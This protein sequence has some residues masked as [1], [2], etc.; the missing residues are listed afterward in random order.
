MINLLLVGDHPCS[1][2]GNGHMMY[3]IAKQID[4]SKIKFSILATKP[5]TA[6]ETESLFEV[7]IWN[8]ID[9][10]SERNPNGWMATLTNLTQSKKQRVDV[11]LFVGHDLWMF[12]Q[13]LPSLTQLKNEK[14]FIIASLFPFD[15]ISVK[16]YILEWLKHIDLPLVYSKYGYDMLKPHVKDIEYFRPPLFDADQ[17]KPYSAKEKVAARLEFSKGLMK[18]DAFVF[19]FFGANQWRKDPQRLIKSFFEVKAKEKK[20]NLYLH[21]ELTSGIFNIDK[22]MRDCGDPAGF[23]FIKK[24]KYQYDTKGMVDAYNLVDCMVNTSW[25]E[26]LSWTLVEAM[27]CGT[28]IIAANNTAQMELIKGGAAFP[29]KCNELAYLPVETNQGQS[30]IETIACD[31]NHL[32]HQMLKAIR[33]PKLLKET[34]LKGLERAKDWISGIDDINKAIL[35]AIEKRKS[36]KLEVKEEPSNSKIKAVLFAQHS[37][38]GDVF[39]TTKAFKGVKKMYSNLPIVYMTMPQ[40]MDIIINNPYID[41]VIPWNEKIEGQYQFNL[42]PHRDRIGPGHWGRNSNSILSDFYWK[43][44]LVEPDDFFIEKVEP[45]QNISLSIT[46]E[47]RPI[48]ILHTTGGDAA[49]RTYKYMGDIAEALKDRYFTIQLGGPKDYPANAQL[50]LRGALSYRES[51]WVVNKARMAVTVDSFM[52]HLCGALGISQVCLFGCGNHNVVRPDQRGGILTCLAID[53][54]RDCP[55]LGPC[56]ASVRNCPL[57]CT[58]RHN[59]KKILLEFE[60]IEKELEKYEM[61]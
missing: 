48:C 58:G 45:S 33:N 40:Y 60:K 10:F 43:L 56:S 47:Q 13:V 21:M 14:D 28:P 53:Y 57:P 52:S 41:K 5:R 16:D 36:S 32:T 26:G 12:A 22:Y 18:R 39:M 15:M 25:Q 49:F 20:A 3:E 24:Q 1:P 8:I 55:G 23:V 4:T 54:I 2:T 7:P 51:A 59:P 34:G 38:A 29:V 35:G 31:R 50:D 17:F 46:N 37:S 30:Y 19:G 42:N 61:S 6:I 11:V 27:L 9:L 44:L